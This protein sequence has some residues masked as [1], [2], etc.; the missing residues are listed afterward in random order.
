[1]IIYLGTPSSELQINFGTLQIDTE[2]SSTG[3]I[4][5]FKG[6]RKLGRDFYKMSMNHD[7]IPF[8][9]SQEYQKLVSEV[10]LPVYILPIKEE[11]GG[12]NIF[13]HIHSYLK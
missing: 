2:N 7:I 4:Y 13:S 8:K 1:M 9:V 11:G 6:N 12:G 10:F 3:F 5:M